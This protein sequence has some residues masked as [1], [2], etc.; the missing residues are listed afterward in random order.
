VLKDPRL[1]AL[2]WG[3]VAWLVAT[4]AFGQVNTEILRKRIKQKGVSF[5]L[6]G[7]FDGHTG[8]TQG[9][10]ADG[11][12][13]GGMVSGRHL[14]FAFASVDY[15]KL[16]GTLSVDK[17]FAHVRYN[18]EL[19]PIV[20]WEVFAQAQSDY[21]QLLQIRNLFGLGPR[22]AAYED[23]HVG[24]FV[25]V[26]YMLERDVYDLAPGT[27]EQPTPVYSRLST[28][29]SA[30]ATLSDGI[31]AV[32]T[33][34]FQ[35]RVEDPADLRIQSDSGF[36]FKVTKVFSTGITFSAHYD[37]RPAPGALPTDAELKNVLSL[38]L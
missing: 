18:F 22:L 37:S 7:T 29:L 12:L 13:G 8:N 4:D 3:A 14:A 35:P 26:A 17:S 11:L 24:I 33:T 25:G 36:V 19:C 34:Y 23:E 6:E 15:T 27:P 30:H 16:N 28:Y 32:T 9:L 21:F 38:A 20:W 5:I 10:S 1:H 31:D 2:A